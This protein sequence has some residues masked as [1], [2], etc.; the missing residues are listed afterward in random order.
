MIFI[1]EGSTSTI[2]VGPFVDVGDGFTPETAIT[3]TATD[4][5]IASLS[6]GTEVDI[7]A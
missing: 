6:D 4:D 2:R 3:F 5:A 7:N 1:R